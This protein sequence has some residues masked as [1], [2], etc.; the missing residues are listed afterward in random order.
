MTAEFSETG[1]VFGHRRSAFFEFYFF[2]SLTC[3]CMLLFYIKPYIHSVR[4]VDT[5][6]STVSLASST[7][8]FWS[9][10][11]SVGQWFIRWPT[12][13]SANVSPI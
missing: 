3:E 1:S 4:I 2:I 9:V 13:F 5:F 6:F 7:L 8:C 12:L 11:R 10:G